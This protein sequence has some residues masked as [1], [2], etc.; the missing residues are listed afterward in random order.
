MSSAQKI[1]K[2]LALAFASFLIFVI[3]TSII[4]GMTILSNIF[5][6]NDNNNQTVEKNEILIS[7]WEDLNIDLATSDLIIKTGNEFK[8]ETTNKYI[9]SKEEN[10]KLYITE[11]NHN[12]FKN[13]NSKV[14]IYLNENQELNNVKINQGAGK[15]TIEK[16]N[17]EY[18]FL[19][20]GAGKSTI[21]NLNIKNST[22]IETGMGKTTIKNSILNNLNINTGIGKTTL[23]AELL[24]TSKIDNGIGKTSIKLI[25]SGNN[26]QINVDKGI[27]SYKVNG[28]SINDKKTIGNGINKININGGIGSI[29]LDFIEKY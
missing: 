4:S 15:V 1:I 7:D 24:G 21:N 13:E 8:V 22:K 11:K 5:D 27:G 29:S 2:Y 28:K 16:L 6:D 18:L 25:G 17:A 14:V 19:D 26:Y 3:I 10:N 23:S 12:I 20:L 9:T